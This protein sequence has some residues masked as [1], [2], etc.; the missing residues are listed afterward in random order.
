MS[1]RILPL[2]V[3][4]AFSSRY[5]GSSC[6]IQG[7]G[8]TI[9]LD[10]PDPI[11]K[12]IREANERSGWSVRAE[13]LSEVVLTHLH[14][15]HCNGIE[16]LGFLHWLQRQQHG[17]PRPRIHCG[18][19]VAE[20]LW[21]K[22]AP[23]MDQDGRA[24]ISD[25]LDLC[26]LPESGQRIV[27]GITIEWRRTT[28]MIPTWAFRFRVKDASFGW[29]SDTG[30]DRTLIDWLAECDAFAHETTPPPYH[31]SIEELNAL[32]EAIRRKM[33]L[34]HLTDSFDP[35]STDIRVMQEG[36]AMEISDGALKFVP[37]CV[38]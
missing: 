10:C 3:G 28:H 17:T 8:G 25:Y 23:A 34:M 7:T 21:T 36:M 1:L 30:F 35:S 2:G 12:V 31:T 14:G 26:T 33:V 15:D 5:Y 38:G 9:L 32:P 27:G 16:V 19:E 6:V 4:S 13:D 37:S 20:R 22:L 29:S 24:G 11:R 18:K